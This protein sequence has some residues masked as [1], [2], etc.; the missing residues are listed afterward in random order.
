MLALC[1]HIVADQSHS[2]QGNWRCSSTP[3]ELNRV[4]AIR[5]TRQAKFPMSAIA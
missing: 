5:K 3:T 4:D 1:I 2:Y